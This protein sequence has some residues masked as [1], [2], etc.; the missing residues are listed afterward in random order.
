VAPL[1]LRLYRLLKK[2][3]SRPQRLKAPLIPWQL[4]HRTSDAL[5]R[6]MGFSNCLAAEGRGSRALETGQFLVG[7]IWH[8][9]TL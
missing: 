8:Q 2:Y 6:I 4:R 1:N 3:C 7:Y 5:I 9:R